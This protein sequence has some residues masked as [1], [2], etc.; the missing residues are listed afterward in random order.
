MPLP[1]VGP[2]SLQEPPLRSRGG[3]A[4][5]G[6]RPLSGDPRSITAPRRV[7][8]LCPHSAPRLTSQFPLRGGSRVS[9][10]PGPQSPNARPPNGSSVSRAAY[11]A[12]RGRSS[13]SSGG[14]RCPGPRPLQRAKSLPLRGP[15]ASAWSWFL[16]QARGPLQRDSCAEKKKPPTALKW[17]GGEKEGRAVGRVCMPRPAF[18]CPAT[19]QVTPFI[20]ALT[21]ARCSA[22]PSPSPFPPSPAPRPSPYPA[23][24]LYFLAQCWV[25]QG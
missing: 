9:L 13:G 15:G 11:R 8:T 14:S 4:L 5:G 25:S 16:R 17:G 19:P 7:P 22:C 12:Q 6:A 23:P 10:F 2:Q 24:P 1:Q 3:C 21:P 20:P 18:N